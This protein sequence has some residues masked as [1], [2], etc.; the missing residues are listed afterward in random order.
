MECCELRVVA[1][2]S[3]STPKTY[4]SNDHYRPYCQTDLCVVVDSELVDLECV[5]STNLVWQDYLHCSFQAVVVP[6][7]QFFALALTFMQDKAFNVL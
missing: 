3:R 5:R 4:G 7:S 6:F 2:A 1:L